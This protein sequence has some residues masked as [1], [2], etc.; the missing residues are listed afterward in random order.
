MLFHCL[1]HG[2]VL[3][4]LA[5]QFPVYFLSLQCDGEIEYVFFFPHLFNHSRYYMTQ[6]LILPVITYN[7]LRSE[8]IKS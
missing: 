7:F 6:K 5:T 2:L 3:L 8:F 1:S 4:P